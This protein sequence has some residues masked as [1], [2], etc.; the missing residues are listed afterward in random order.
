MTQTEHHAP[1]FDRTLNVED[2]IRLLAPKAACK[3]LFFNDPIARL[4]R[5]KP[6]HVLLSQDGIASRRYLPFFDYPYADLMR[7]LA[8]TA[9]AVYPELPLG[10]G[11]RRL[12]R[13]GYEALL[14]SQVGKVIFG[15]FGRNFESVVKT[16]ARGWAV[17]I[18]FGKVDVEV[19]GP[20]HVRYHF[21]NLPGF[22]ETYQVGIVEGAMNV[23]GVRG[24][25]GVHLKDLA[26]GS[27]DIRWG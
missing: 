12:G 22:L 8:G 27:F 5:A 19:V 9:G 16:G 13:T 21:E 20:N 10:E 1:R 23:C 14:E 3:G 18:N 15:I 4:R 7:I 26:N 6:D 25:I 2:H 11:L 17:S 24:E